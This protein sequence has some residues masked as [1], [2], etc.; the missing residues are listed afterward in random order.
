[1]N[2][3]RLGWT[4]VH[5][6]WQG[7]AIVA[8]YAAVRRLFASTNGRYLLACVA[9]AMMI[10]APAVTWFAIEQSQDALAVVAADRTAIVPGS[11]APLAAP[12]PVVVESSVPRVQKTPWLQWAVAVWIV[13]ASALSLRLLGGWMIAARMRSK[14]TRTA[15]LEGREAIER[16]R[17]RLGIAR[18]VGLRVSAMVQSPVVIGA[19]RPLVLVPV[20]MLAA[21]PAARWKH[22]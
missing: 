13:G 15:P 16:L 7:A 18:A 2:T 1:M 10:T 9:L 14:C 12:L 4:L 21:L 20:G 6:L 8:V 17:A 11:V 22:Y 5:F 19:W 3:E